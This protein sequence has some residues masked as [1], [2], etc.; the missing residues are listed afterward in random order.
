V[1]LGWSLISPEGLAEQTDRAGRYA[2]FLQLVA[3]QVAMTFPCTG[4]ESA[5]E[6]G[7][8]YV[9]KNNITMLHTIISSGFLYHY[10][11]A[12]DPLL[13]LCLVNIVS[14][15]SKM[16]CFLWL[17]APQGMGPRLPVPSFFDSRLAREMYGFGAKSFV[18]NTSTSIE[19]RSAVLIIGG[20]LGP[21]AVV[22]YSIP[23]ALLNN[24]RSLIST[25]TH[26]LMPAFSELDSLGQQERSKSL[27]LATSRLTVGFITM[28]CVGVV[29]LGDSFIGLWIGQEYMSEGRILLFILTGYLFVGML[30]PLGGRYMT[31][32]GRHGVLAKI[33]MVR[34]LTNL[35][36][37]VALVKPLG[38]PGVALGSLLATLATFPLESRAI[39]GSME[40]GLL[41]Y[42]RGTFLPAVGPALAMFLLAMGG[43]MLG[44]TGGWFGFLFT[45]AISSLAF[46]LLYLAF[47]VRPED[48]ARFIRLL[49]AA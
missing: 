18:Q 27:F 6:G 41:Y 49:G 5:L 28:L 12:W 10:M 11:L 29:T 33:C 43:N 34:A 7:Q 1:F 47:G 23:Q 40:I 45:G 17:L 31:A 24:I 44:L 2:L 48:R 22:F 38:P 13:L 14:C 30:L 20:F 46:V 37:S 32:V 16:A 25:L 3:L 4:L 9:A 42:L 39:L 15:L 19:G 36:I 35:C 26:A 8:R 21:A